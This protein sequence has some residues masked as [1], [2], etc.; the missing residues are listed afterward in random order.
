MI[1]KTADINRFNTNFFFNGQRLKTSRPNVLWYLFYII[2]GEVSGHM[3]M[4]ISGSQN[5]DTLNTAPKFCK[6]KKI[7]TE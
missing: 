3:Q 7:L 1:G 2:T 6:D 5:N 4:E